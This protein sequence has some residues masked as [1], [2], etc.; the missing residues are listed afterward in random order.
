[1]DDKNKILLPIVIFNMVF[2]F[3][4]LFFN[5]VVFS[6]FTWT[7]LFVGILLGAVAAGITFGAMAMKK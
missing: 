6:V 2:I 1:M 4:Q 5:G 7:K 3:Y